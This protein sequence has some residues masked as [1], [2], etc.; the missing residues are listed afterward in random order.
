MAVLQLCY[1]GVRI[2]LQLCYNLFVAPLAG[3]QERSSNEMFQWCYS[4]VTMVLELCY[5]GVK[6]VLQLSCVMTFV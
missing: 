4:C 3:P 6:I 5:N 1:S 2:M